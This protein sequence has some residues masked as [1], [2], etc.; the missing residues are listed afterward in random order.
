MKDFKQRHGDTPTKFGGASA[1]S[2]PS[3]KSASKVKNT[4]K[5]EDSDEEKALETPSKKRKR[6]AKAECDNIV[7]K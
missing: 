4:V 6:A 1:M 7:V 2:T 5:E 3:K